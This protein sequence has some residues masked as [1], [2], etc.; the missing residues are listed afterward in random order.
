MHI[1]PVF[2]FAVFVFWLISVAMDGPLAAAI[3]MS[4][5]SAAFLPVHIVS[6]LII[7]LF[8]PE[9]IFRSLFFSGCVLTAA[10]TMLLPV[11]GPYAGPWIMALMGLSGAVLAIGACMTLKKSPA[12]LLCAAIGLFSANIVLLFV[13]LW[14]GGSKLYF[15]AIALLLLAIPVLG[16]R[17]PDT[18]TAAAPTDGPWHYLPFIL[19]FKVICGLMYSFIIPAYQQFPVIPGLELLFYIMAVFAGYWMSRKNRDLALICGVVLGMAA[20]TLLHAGN[21]PYSSNSSMFALQASTGF[22]DIVLISILLALPE[23]VR[24]FGTG[25]AVLCTGIITG[26]LIG[27]YFGHMNELIAMAGHIVLNLSV[28]TLYFLGRYG[29]IEKQTQAPE[30]HPPPQGDIKKPE[31]AEE[32]PRYIRMLLSEREYFV[33]KNVMLGSTYKQTALELEI[34][35]STVK[36]YMH[37]V[38]DKVGVNGKKELFERLNDM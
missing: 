27:H 23:P 6:L 22:V 3:G 1:I 11:A 36:T 19:I 31:P 25:L 9:N 4:K 10:L 8:C 13:M 7:G 17:L 2:C 15:P 37:R 38:Y 26:K 28:L 16:I 34:S 14:P 32:M 35:E 30:N 5:A 33:L 18:K 24:A 21:G 29:Y 20:F 12:P